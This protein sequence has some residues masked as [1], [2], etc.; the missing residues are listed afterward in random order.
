[1]KDFESVIQVS[2]LGLDFDF[3]SILNFVYMNEQI[4]MKNMLSRSKWVYYWLVGFGL[5][6]VQ[7][8]LLIVRLGLVEF[9]GWVIY[10]QL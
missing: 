9:V 5:V 6:R 4:Y 8:T 7:V 3:G 1:M 10:R 2:K